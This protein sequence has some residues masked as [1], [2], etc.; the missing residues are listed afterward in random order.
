MRAGLLV[1]AVV[2][3]HLLEW[4]S[5]RFWTSEL[6]LRMSNFLGVPMHRV[7]RDVVSCG[8]Q[9]FNYTVS[10]T[11]IDVCCGAIVLTWN[12][13]RSI[14]GNLLM[15]AEIASGLFVFNIIR[16][17]IGFVLYGNGVPWLIG[18]EAMSGVA[19]FM[20][21]LWL[22]R[23]FDDPIARF[24]EGLPSRRERARQVPVGSGL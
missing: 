5:L 6:V 22:M 23:Q 10:C 3:C 18:H 20:V 21:W 14:A 9:M 15:V 1:A 17:T 19:Y 8:G 4:N 7:S 24:I 13:A 2:A 16:L 12:R 11:F